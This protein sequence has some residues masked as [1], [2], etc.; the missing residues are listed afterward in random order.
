MQ[1]V[2]VI[3]L[4]GGLEKMHILWEKVRSLYREEEKRECDSLQESAEHEATRTQFYEGV[5]S[6]F[7]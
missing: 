4:L 7:Y 1:A 6:P 5:N 3:I 2:V